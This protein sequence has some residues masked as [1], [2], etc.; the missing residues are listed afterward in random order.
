MWASVRVVVNDGGAS[1]WWIVRLV[2]SGEE[3]ADL[4]VGVEPSVVQ[5]VG[6]RVTLLGIGNLGTENPSGVELD[7]SGRPGEVAEDAAEGVEP[8]EADVPGDDDVG[9]RVSGD[10]RCRAGGAGRQEVG[11]SGE[12]FGA[13]GLALADAGQCPGA[14]VIGG[15]GPLGEDD[16]DL[17]VAQSGREIAEGGEFGRGVGGLTVEEV[18]GESVA[19]DV[20]TR[21]G[22]EFALEDVARVHPGHGGDDPRAEQ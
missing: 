14:L 22:Q 11:E 4:V 6:E 5:P 18:V 19:D 9:P 1:G 2:R 15:A 21:V 13:L 12:S 16:G 20:E 3:L 10:Q 8:V 7:V 17:I